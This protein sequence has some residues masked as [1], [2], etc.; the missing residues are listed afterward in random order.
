MTFNV[1]SGPNKQKFS[2]HKELLGRKSPALKAAFDGRFKE[3]HTNEMNLPEDDLEAFSL[4]V[5]WL[6]TSHIP[7]QRANPEGDM[8]AATAQYFHLFVLAGKY[9][10]PDLEKCCY[11]AIHQLLGT[12]TMPDLLFLEELFNIELSSSRLK[13]YMINVCAYFM[14]QEKVVN[15][16]FEDFLKS[17]SKFAAYLC[18]VIVWWARLG[19]QFNSLLQDHPEL[20]PSFRRYFTTRTEGDEFEVAERLTKFLEDELDASKAKKKAK[21]SHGSARATGGSTAK[22]VKRERASIR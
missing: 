13:F 7:R 22:M 14:L 20:Q 5:S 11:T 10:I 2:V 12:K 17:H 3:G 4:L 9:L 15:K 6:Y 1:R 18:R 8:T 19:A 16:P 21:L